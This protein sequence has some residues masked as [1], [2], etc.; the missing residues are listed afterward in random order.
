MN[1]SAVISNPLLRNLPFKIEMNNWGKILMSPAGNRHGRLQYRI[2][3]RIDNAKGSGE[4]IMECS[5]QTAA[6]V[7]VAD[8]AWAS[9]EFIRQHGCDTPYPHAP[10]LCVEVMPSS[11]SRGEIEEKVQLYLTSGAHEVWVVF[12]DERI[13]YHTCQGRRRNS[14]EAP[15]A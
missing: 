14:A 12:E 8:A 11:N 5:V 6:G 7:K 13:E 15:S 3:R 9:D 10:E 4:I 1:W 2:G